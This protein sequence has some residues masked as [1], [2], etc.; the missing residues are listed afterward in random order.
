MAAKRSASKKKTA[1]KKTA[2]KRGRSTKKPA[3]KSAAR[4]SKV[5]KTDTRLEEIQTIIDVML[6]AGA[7]ELETD[8]GR[9]GRLRVR[10]KEDLPPNIVTTAMAPAPMAAA[11][12]AAAAAAPVAPAPTS[13]E[14]E[15]ADEVLAS[16]M[17]GTF[18]RA[19]SPEAESFV[20]V[21]DSVDEDTTICVIE[22]MKVM[23]EIKAEM[24]GRILGILVENGEPVEFGQPL[25]RVTRD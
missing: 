20:S 3:R 11:P 14:S 10:L 12:I 21:G 8:D 17:V 9:G 6:A 1:G 15:E 7:V 22:A 5:E 19:S 4:T 18:Y 25:F 16:P 23:N 2:A 24:T 13:A